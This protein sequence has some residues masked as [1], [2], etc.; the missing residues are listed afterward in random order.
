MTAKRKPALAIVSQNDIAPDA[1]TDLP[2][3]EAPVLDEDAVFVDD[4][5]NELAKSEGDLWRVDN[6]IKA[7][8]EERQRR[9]DSIN[10]TFDAA[11]EQL[12]ARRAIVLRK[13][14]RIQAAL[15]VG[16]AE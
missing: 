3:P 1:D 12:A 13:R 8:L 11:D 16:G 7:S 6:D 5:Q 14:S 15:G 10:R 4:M 2:I 9:I